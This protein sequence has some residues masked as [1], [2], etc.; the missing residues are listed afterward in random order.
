MPTPRFP[1]VPKD[2]LTKAQKRVYDAIAG[3]P[4]GGVRG[5]FA[6]LLRSPELADLVQK[7]GEVRVVRAP[8]AG[9]EGRP[10]GVHCR[11]RG[12]GRPPGGD[13]G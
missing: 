10:C 7:L 1:D 2:R 12:A 3:G 8:S 11:R 4:R 9:A 5:P 6:V 13:E